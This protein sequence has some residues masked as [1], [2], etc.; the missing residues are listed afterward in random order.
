MIARYVERL[1]A[2]RQ[3]PADS[4]RIAGPMGSAPLS[5]RGTA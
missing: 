2:A 3:L 4:L 1:L 5:D